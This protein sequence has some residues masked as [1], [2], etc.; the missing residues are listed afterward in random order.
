MCFVLTNAQAQR[1]KSKVVAWHAKDYHTHTYCVEG[2]PHT[3]A[4]LSAFLARVRPLF[5]EVTWRI[6]YFEA[7]T[8]VMGAPA[9]PSYLSARGAVGANADTH[10]LPTLTRGTGG[11]AAME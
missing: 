7:P 9:P 5:A 8:L 11:V 3:M 10:R 1:Y 2:F 6:V 4:S